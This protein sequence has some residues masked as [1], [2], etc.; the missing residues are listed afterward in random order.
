[1][2]ENLRPVTVVVSDGNSFKTV[3]GNE[4]MTPGG[5]Y[6]FE[7]KLTAGFMTK[8]GICRGQIDTNKVR[9]TDDII[10]KCW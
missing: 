5:R 10:V 7:V 1:M 6:F 9:M 8:I 4:P 2:N 3:I